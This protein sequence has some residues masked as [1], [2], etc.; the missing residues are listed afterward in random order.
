MSSYGTTY[1][2]NNASDFA[3]AI[4]NGAGYDR[5]TTAINILDNATTKLTLP[6]SWPV[7]VYDGFGARFDTSLVVTPAVGSTGTLVLFYKPLDTGVT[8]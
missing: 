2:A 3:G 4:N 7:G 1:L 6:V 8:W 5:G